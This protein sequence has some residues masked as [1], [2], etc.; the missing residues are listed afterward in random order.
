[1]CQFRG[2]QPEWGCGGQ[3]ILL[4]GFIMTGLSHCPPSSGLAELFEDADD[5]AGGTR[6]AGL[7][8]VSEQCWPHALGVMEELPRKHRLHLRRD[9]ADGGR[10]Q[11]H[12]SLRPR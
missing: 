8:G 1:M 2:S 4:P 10:A 3:S 7:G 5:V 12:V 11:V 6:G 9:R